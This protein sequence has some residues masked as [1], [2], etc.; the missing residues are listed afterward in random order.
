MCNILVSF[1]RVSTI[2]S[3]YAEKRVIVGSV[4]LEMHELRG[5]GRKELVEAVSA[6][7]MMV[8]GDLVWTRRGMTWSLVLTLVESTSSSG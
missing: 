6:A 7:G 5:F 4:M 1:R 3:A 8:A 2:T